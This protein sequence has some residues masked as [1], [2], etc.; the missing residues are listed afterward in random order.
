MTTRMS[1]SSPKQQQQRKS[2]EEEEEPS[3]SSSLVVSNSKIWELPD[4]LLYSIA[5]F[6]VPETQRANLLCTKIATLCK[7]SYRTIIVDGSSNNN[8]ESQAS[9]GGLWELVL[10]GD[11]GVIINS[12]SSNEINSNFKNKNN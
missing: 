12:S 11:Y 2:K 3:S 4:V 9:I 5:S 1:L 7:P 10:A 8:N 6:V